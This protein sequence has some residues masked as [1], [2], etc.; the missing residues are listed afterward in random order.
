MSDDIECTLEKDIPRYT[1]ER[2]QTRAKAFAEDLNSAM[3]D[4]NDDVTLYAM[5]DY[6]HSKHS[7]VIDKI[8][9]LIDVDDEGHLM[10]GSTRQQVGE[11]EDQRDIANKVRAT[12]KDLQKIL[13]DELT[14]E[15]TQ[16]A[17]RSFVA[18][19]AERCE[20]ENILVLRCVQK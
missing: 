2:L 18:I 15:V 8:A 1:E 7:D 3:S 4:I 5:L 11:D 16:E 6:P 13:S 19:G 17:N 12:R 9:F 20:G 14:I 10:T